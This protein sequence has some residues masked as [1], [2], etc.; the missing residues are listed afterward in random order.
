MR[1]LK[2]GNYPGPTLVKTGVKAFF[3]EDEVMYIFNRSGGPKR[4]L[5]LANGTGVFECDYY[6]NPKNDGEIF[7][8]FFNYTNEDILI[9]KGDRIGQAVFQKFLKADNDSFIDRDRIAG[10]GSTDK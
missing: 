2:N 1:K 3:N 7:F 9:K 10:F 5:V 8:A 6:S 4:G